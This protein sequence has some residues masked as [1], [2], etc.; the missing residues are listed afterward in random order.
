MPRT[1]Q[2]EIPNY[3]P[4]TLENEAAAEQ[5]EASLSEIDKPIPK[6]RKHRRKPPP[7]LHPRIAGEVTVGAERIVVFVHRRG[8]RI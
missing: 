2:E 6:E 1:E 4:E 8:K 3:D 5:F 7:K